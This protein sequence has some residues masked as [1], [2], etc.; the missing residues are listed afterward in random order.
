MHPPSTERPRAHHDERLGPGRSAAPDD[1][2]LVLLPSGP[3]TV[4]GSPL[5]GTRSSTSHRR[6]AFENGD[7]GRGFSPAGADCRYRAPLVP[8]L[9][10]PAEGYRGRRTAGRRDGAAA[11]VQARTAVWYPLPRRGV[12][13]V[14]GAA[15]EK[16]CAKAPRVRIPPSPPHVDRRTRTRAGRPRPAGSHSPSGER[17]P[18]GL[19]RRTGNAVRGNPSRVRIPALPP[20]RRDR[21]DPPAPSS[22]CGDG[23]TNRASASSRRMPLTTLIRRGSDGCWASWMT[24]PAAPSRVFGI[25]KT[26]AS[27]S[28]CEQRPDAHRARLVG[29][30]DRGVREADPSRA[31]GRPRAGRRR[32]RGRSG[33]SV[34]WTRSWARATIASSTTATAATG[35]SPAASASC[36]SAS[37]S[38]MNSS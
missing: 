24:V 13:V 33:R 9:A 31:C 26:S 2:R 36:A 22:A 21:H 12:R 25:A 28:L 7:L 3:D 17:S 38:P 37:A 34:A 8:R 30:E 19:W 5:R 20:H 1:D 16:R 10:R 23:S 29:R 18:S 35:R 11:T 14:D 32:R 27:T 6:A 15:L 4:R